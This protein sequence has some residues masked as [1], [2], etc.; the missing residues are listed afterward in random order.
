MA[1]NLHRLVFAGALLVALLAAVPALAQIPDQEA[2]VERVMVNNDGSVTVSG[3]LPNPC[4]R[5]LPPHQTITGRTITITLR[6]RAI[7]GVMCAQVIKPFETTIAIDTAG[8]SAGTYTV[9]VNGVSATLTLAQGVAAPNRP[10]PPAAAPDA[11][12]PSASDCLTRMTH[13]RSYQDNQ[14]GFCLLYPPTYRI[15][16]HEDSETAISIV[17]ETD[18]ANGPALGISHEAA[19]GRTLDDVADAAQ[20]EYPNR[21]ITFDQTSIGGLPAVVT[22]DFPGR[23]A[24]RQAFVFANDR[25]FRLVLEPSQ[26][27][28]D[29]L[30]ETV[31]ES[32]IFFP[33]IDST[34]KDRCER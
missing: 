27:G 29:D 14:A 22:E 18:A 1:L 10:T 13:S 6:A 3:S 32:L 7:Q 12:T 21:S 15:I 30:W 23:R 16:E 2:W 28:A 24:T 9:V 25:L 8:L 26:T 19:A 33:P 31:T 34:P 4:Y 17:P 20:A 5:L 11:P